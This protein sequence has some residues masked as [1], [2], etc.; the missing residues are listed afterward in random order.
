MHL[1]NS[2][3]TQEGVS[4][5]G[6]RAPD[7]PRRSGGAQ[8]MPDAKLSESGLNSRRRRDALRDWEVP[9]NGPE[10]T[11]RINLGLAIFQ[12][13]AL[14]GVRYTH[15]EI[16]AWAGVSGAMIYLIEQ[17]AMKKLRTRLRIMK[18]PVL[19]E[20]VAQIFDGRTPATGSE[21]F[22]AL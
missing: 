18:D 21:K 22:Y 17:Q 12:A 5:S 15:D 2:T 13:H 20:L 19:I 14:P 10:K 9:A 1:N 4:E 6:S 7:R 11:A 16:G 3:P 8:R